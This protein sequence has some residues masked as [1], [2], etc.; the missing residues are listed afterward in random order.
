MNPRLI[1]AKIDILFDDWRKH[2]PPISL[3]Y[4]LKILRFKLNDG[5]FCST[6]HKIILHIESE[7]F[8]L[9]DVIMK[10]IHMVIWNTKL[11]TY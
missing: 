9:K 11:L 6:E 3:R 4:L 1:P 2:I 8:E 5:Y 7:Y 10:T